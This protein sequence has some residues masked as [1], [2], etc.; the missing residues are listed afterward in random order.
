MNPV[1][2]VNPV[3]FRQLGN[4]RVG[5]NSWGALVTAPGFT[6]FLFLLGRGIYM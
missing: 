4:W 1:N 2:P 3:D 5:G 6:V